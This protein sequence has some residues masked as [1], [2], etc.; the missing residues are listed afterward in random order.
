ML[1]RQTFLE[2]SK[3]LADSGEITSDIWL[4]DPI[5]ALWVELRAQNGG[6]Y[7][8]ANTL[9]GCID[10]IEVI[11]GSNVLLS[12]DGYEAFAIGA[13]RQGHFGQQLIAET[14]D[15]YQNCFFPI[16]FGRWFGDEVLALDPTHFNNLQVRFKW[17]LANV[18]AVGATGFLTGTGRLNI[19]AD[20][21]EGAT[22]PVGVV[23]YKE[24]YSF[25][26]GDSGVEYVDLPTDYPHKAL[27][28][29]SY[30]AGVGGL[31][32]ISNI[33]VSCDQGKFV[34]LDMSKSNFLRWLSLRQQP[35]NYK[36]ALKVT[37]G[38]TAYFVTKY[39][40]EVAYQ[41]EVADCICNA[42]NS[43]IGEQTVLLHTAGV[44]DTAYRNV[45]AF[46][47]GF[48]P[49]STAYMP[50]GEY[51]DANTWLNPS[52]F[53]SIRLELTQDGAGGSAFVVV[54]QVRPY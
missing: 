25:T 10:S 36:Q 51:D 48:L 39:L 11:D 40:E 54:E 44:A 27:Y 53:R 19:L 7:N 21:M 50:W 16:F 49:Y 37:N 28:I 5:T 15:V 35:F 34:P 26:T 22:P 3:V 33:K 30:E 45:G 24:H 8:L 2:N 12:L 23:T 46:V 13:Y 14:E 4:R 47:H 17:N 41:P 9:A 38:T 32:N 18:N 20:V 52:L 1:R 31:S 43:G 42:P 6:T 29:R